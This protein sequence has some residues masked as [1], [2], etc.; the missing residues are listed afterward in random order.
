MAAVPDAKLVT[1]LDVL[2]DTASQQ[3]DSRARLVA[4]AMLPGPRSCY[5]SREW[6]RQP[7]EGVDPAGYYPN[8]HGNEWLRLEAACEVRA[9]NIARRRK[10]S[11]GAIVVALVAA[12]GGVWWMWRRRR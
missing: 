3:R 2:A 12:L 11:V 9:T 8:L 7:D 1:L 4:R 6:Y 5:G 10:A